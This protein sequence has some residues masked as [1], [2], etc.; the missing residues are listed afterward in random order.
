MRLTLDWDSDQIKEM[1]F[2][3]V[4]DRQPVDAQ[5]ERLANFAEDSG[6]S[7]QWELWHSSNHG[8]G[9]ENGYHYIEY[10]NVADLED[11]RRLRTAYGDDRMRISMDGKRMEWGSPFVNVLYH[12]KNISPNEHKP[13]ETTN[14]AKLVERHGFEES[15]AADTKDPETGNVDYGALIEALAD[16]SDFGSRP[17]VYRRVMQRPSVEVGNDSADRFGSYAR[18]RPYDIVEGRRQPQAAEAKALRDYAQSRDIGHYGAPVGEP[19]DLAEKP[20]R[21]TFH[22]YWEMPEFEFDTQNF[23]PEP[24]ETN[25]DWYPANFRTGSYGSEVDEM[26]LKQAHD[27]IVDTIRDMLSP[28]SEVTHT[29]EDGNTT[30]TVHGFERPVDRYGHRISLE[31]DRP[32]DRDEAARYRKMWHDN[33]P[34]HTRD[35][36]EAILDRHDVAPFGENSAHWECIIFDGED[37]L[38]SEGGTSPWWIARGVFDASDPD[39]VAAPIKNSAIVAD[40]MGFF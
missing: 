6:A 10:G 25:S 29:D 19:E 8:N 28:S 38:K 26:T 27:S 39:A 16:H 40:T 1:H 18:Q 34:D 17:A 31:R 2:P 11:A 7:D 15:E 35:G 9:E 24:G 36:V 32:L 5:H 3:A 20:H 4:R 21:T 13:Y 12:L 37:A 14:R 22:E 33:Q 23:D 30:T